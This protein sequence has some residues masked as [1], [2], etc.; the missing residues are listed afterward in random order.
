[1]AID[2]L[3]EAISQYQVQLMLHLKIT[4]TEQRI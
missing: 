4:Q 3:Q 1:M 2:D